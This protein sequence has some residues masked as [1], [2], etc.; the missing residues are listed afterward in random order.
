MGRH[1]QEKEDHGYRGIL[2]GNR[3]PMTIPKQDITH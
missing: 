2:S 1:I 3:P